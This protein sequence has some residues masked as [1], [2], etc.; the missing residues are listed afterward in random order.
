V[1]SP[2]AVFSSLATLTVIT[3]FA[4]TYPAMRAANLSPIECLRSE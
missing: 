1:I 2:V 3:L 4:G